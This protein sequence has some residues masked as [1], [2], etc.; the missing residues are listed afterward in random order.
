MPN[1]R[2]FRVVLQSAVLQRR[3]LEPPAERARLW[4]LEGVTTVPYGTAAR[5]RCTEGAMSS[6]GPESS[7]MLE[8]LADWSE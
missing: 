1:D 4:D 8:M 3:D 6:P 5:S 7:G 2:I